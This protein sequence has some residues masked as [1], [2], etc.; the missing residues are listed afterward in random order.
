[1]R[2]MA[3]DAHTDRLPKRRNQGTCCF[4]SVNQ[5][6]AVASLGARQ[7]ALGESEPPDPIFGPLGSAE[8][9]N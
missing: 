8:R 1:M 4:N 6:S 5:T 7:S 2:K 9:L 3:D